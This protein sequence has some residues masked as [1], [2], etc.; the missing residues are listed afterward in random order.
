MSATVRT[1]VCLAVWLSVCQVRGFHIPPKMNKTIQ[2]LIHHYNVPQKLMF[3]GSPVFSRELLSGKMETKRIFLGGV[4]ETYEKIINHMLKELPTPT[5]QTDTSAPVGAAGS[6]GSEDVKTQLNYILKMVREL[7][8]HHYEEQDKLLQRLQDLKHIKMD[9]RVTQS[10]ALF[11]LQQ[12]YIEASS[13]P[14]DI[15]VQRRRRRRRRQA[16]RVKAQ[17]ARG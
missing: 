11:E 6:Q 14:N 17:R 4:L 1:I 2:D 3:T 10:K 16:W 8:K 15:K 9:D 5:P 13:L 7:R 12:L